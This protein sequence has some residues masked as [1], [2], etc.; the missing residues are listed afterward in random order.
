LLWISSLSEDA[1]PQV[2]GMPVIVLGRADTH[3]ERQ[4]DVFV[5]VGTPGIDA[6]GHLLRTDKVISLYLKR[7]RSA[8]LPSVAQAVDALSARLS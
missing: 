8:N 3:F 1:M 5:P 7:L 2:S 4:P 6:D